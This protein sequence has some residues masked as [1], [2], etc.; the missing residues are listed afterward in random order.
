MKTENGCTDLQS[1]R[2]LCGDIL[3]RRGYTIR[4]M[5]QKIKDDVLYAVRLEHA[6]T[7]LPDPKGEWLEKIVSSE[8]DDQKGNV[9]LRHGLSRTR[10][11]LQMLMA[12]D[13]IASGL[14]YF[15][16]KLANDK[17]PYL[18]AD[19]N[20]TPTSKLLAKEWTPGEPHVP[21]LSVLPPATATLDDSIEELFP[22]HGKKPREGREGPSND[23][24]PEEEEEVDIV[25]PVVTSS[26][27]PTLDLDH[28][29]HQ[30]L[31]A[32]LKRTA[33]S[34]VDDDDDIPAIATQPVPGAF[35]SRKKEKKKKPRIK[36]FK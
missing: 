33:E 14:V 6:K 19:I 29:D 28:S 8:K 12:R 5:D 31:R 22:M 13:V 30:S 15:P 17:L 32:T 25:P 26:S 16:N 34:S 35:G 36:G 21:E 23:I 20:L 10:K 4:D 18:G 11:K 24:R 7:I 3:D 1:S 9:F 2:N 27:Q